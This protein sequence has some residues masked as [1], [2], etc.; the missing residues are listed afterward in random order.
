MTTRYT[1][2]FLQ[3]KTVAK[4]T[5]HICFFNVSC[6]R[7][8]TLYWSVSSVLAVSRTTHYIGLFL[9]YRLSQGLPIILVC[10]FNVNCC[11][12]LVCFFNI[13]RR[14]DYT[15]YRSVSSTQTVTETTHYIGLFLQYRLSQGHAHYIGLFQ[16][17]RY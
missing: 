5:N 3:Q 12:D 2:L 8:Y 1:G 16:S 7:D 14:N 10:L 13:T 11:N 15:L 17:L 6:L 9:Q 4:T